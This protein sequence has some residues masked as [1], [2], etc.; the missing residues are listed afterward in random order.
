MTLTTIFFKEQFLA[1]LLAAEWLFC[2]RLERRK[3]FPWRAALSC[4]LL[5]VA[6]ALLPA[7]PDSVLLTSAQYFGLFVGSL[8]ALGLCLRE[9]VQNLLFCGIAGYTIEQLAYLVF[10]LLDELLFSGIDELGIQIIDPYAGSVSPAEELNPTQLA[11]YLIIY[12]LIYYAIYFVLYTATFDLFDPAIC[13]NHD[14]RLGR[15]G[16]TAFSGLL[17]FADVVFSRV[18]AVYTPEGSVSRYLELL[19]NGMLCVMILALLYVQIARRALRDELVSVQYLL[20]QDKQQ[21]ELAKQAAELVNIKYHDLRHRSSRLFPGEEKAELDAILSAYDQRVQTGN[22]V[23][24]VILTEKNAA[25][26]KKGIQLLCMADGRG[27]DFIKPHHLYTLLSNAIEN[28]M[29]AVEPLPQEER[30]IDLYLRRQ[31]G[32]YCLRIE[33]P[34][35]APVTLRDGL[36]VTRKEDANL[37]G[38][39]MLSM[40][41]IAEQYGGS[42]TVEAEE[43]LFCLNVLLT[44][45]TAES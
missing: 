23:L 17:I 28:A 35:P 3:G 7:Q 19:N 36:P 2:C 38:F 40:K 32:F 16:L 18:T 45:G 13:A 21:Y 27:L 24:D 33:N 37:H 30:V 29:E 22:E 15:A 20:E 14:L 4:L 8:A 9:P 43:G 5:A 1:Q 12:G 31:G 41:T 39:G 10:T 34:C 11:V 6:A 44:G 25:C 42:L 26:R